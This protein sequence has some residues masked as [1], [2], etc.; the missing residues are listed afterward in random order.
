[1]S[2][3][4]KYVGVCKGVGDDFSQITITLLSALGASLAENFTNRAQLL[5]IYMRPVV[6]SVINK[7]S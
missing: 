6:D 7:R 4:R 1:M 5:I 2:I 3:D